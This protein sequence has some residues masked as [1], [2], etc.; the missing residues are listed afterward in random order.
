LKSGC[1]ST[2]ALRG[3]AYERSGWRLCCDSAGWRA[4]RSWW[5]LIRRHPHCLDAS[6]PSTLSKF[7]FARVGQRARWWPS[8]ASKDWQE[9][10][11]TSI[12]CMDKPSASRSWGL[13]KRRLW[14]SSTLHG[15]ENTQ[16]GGITFSLGRLVGEGCMAFE[17]HG[18]IH[19]QIWVEKSRHAGFARWSTQTGY[20]GTWRERRICWEIFY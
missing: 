3:S 19:F 18:E 8:G 16:S 17:S 6:S 5:K 15:E 1:R 11:R 4:R 10:V 13:K 9:Q 2:I 20:D 12:Y 7:M 14:R